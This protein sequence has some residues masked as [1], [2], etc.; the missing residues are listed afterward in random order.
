MKKLIISFSLI[1]LALSINAQV[2]RTIALQGP[3]TVTSQNP[4]V[5]FTAV[6]NRASRLFGAKDDLTSV[7]MVLQAGDTVGVTGSDSTYFHVIF[8]DSEGFVLK[9]HAT[10]IQSV[11]T[12]TSQQ[13]ASVREEQTVHQ[14]Q[15]SRFT[16][17]EN[18]Y[19]TSMAATLI[20][21]K[22]WKGMTPDMVQDSWGTPKKINRTISGNIVKEWWNYN[23]SWLFFEDDILEDWGP[24]K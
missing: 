4:D 22:I 20:A 10:L 3:D 19:G 8:Q 24:L 2:N 11:S 9:R 17:L 5:K 12:N 13:Q 23:N 16:Y 6:L 18:K 1:L 14:P 15:V 21:G 7:I